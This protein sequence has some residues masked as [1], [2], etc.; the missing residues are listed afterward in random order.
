MDIDCTGFYLTVTSPDFRKDH[1]TTN[2]D[3]KIEVYEEVS[4]VQNVKNTEYQ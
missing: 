2:F 3:Q 1:Q 4:S